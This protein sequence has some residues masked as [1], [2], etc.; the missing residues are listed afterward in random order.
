MNRSIRIAVPRL[1]LAL[2]AL[3][4]LTPAT[5]AAPKKTKV[6]TPEIWF[7]SATQISITLVVIAGNTTGAP[8]G[9]TIQWMPAALYELGPDGELGTP[10]D[11]SWGNPA[12]CSGSFSGNAN[13]SRYN[14]GPGEHVLVNI[15]EFLFDEGASTNCPGALE[16]GTEYVFRAFAHA[17]NDIIRSDFTAPP[18][19]A[20]TL[21]CGSDPGCTQGQG[22]WKEHTPLVEDQ[23]SPLYLE[24]PVTTLT[25]GTVSYNVTELVAILDTPPAGGNGLISL[26]HQLI[27]AKLNIANGA[28]GTDAAGSIAAADALIGGLVVPPV[29]SGYLASSATSALVTALQNYNEGATGPGHCS[30]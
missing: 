26:A 10:D 2:G 16:C 11:N 22:Y 17:T 12:L 9:F 29:G 8:A 1:M 19:Y 21:D 23:T 6:D 28:D 30:D 4:L 18:L 15:G 13:L 5:I 27:A 24:W 14:L 25:L 7:D 20:S 3:A